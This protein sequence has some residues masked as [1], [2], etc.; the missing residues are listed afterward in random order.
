VV[1]DLV[2]NSEVC[3][4]VLV[5]LHLYDFIFVTTLVMNTR[6]SDS[7]MGMC[8]M[9]LSCNYNCIMSQKTVKTVSDITLS[10]FHRL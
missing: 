6:S 3:M 4:F 10:N 5:C 1:T 2:S 9:C 8:W 7:E